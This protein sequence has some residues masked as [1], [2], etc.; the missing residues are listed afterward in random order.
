MSGYGV[1]GGFFL[2]W[3]SPLHREGGKGIIAA[4]ANG[5]PTAS[6]ANHQF[7]Q[8]NWLRYLFY[9]PFFLGQTE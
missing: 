7:S 1:G 9:Q 5:W 8:Q 6:E 2:W 4:F 3:D